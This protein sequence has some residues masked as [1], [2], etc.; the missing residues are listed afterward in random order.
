MWC[1]LVSDLV[2]ESSVE[3]PTADARAWYS[4]WAFVSHCWVVNRVGS[5]I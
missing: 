2:R 1:E 5:G 3:C 4:R